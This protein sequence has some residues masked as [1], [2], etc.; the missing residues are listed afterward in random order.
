MATRF[1]PLVLP[2]QLH[3]FPQSYSQRIKLYDAERNFSAQKH[4]YWFNYFIDLEE[5]D[6]ANVKIRLFTQIFSG[7]V[8]KWFKSLLAISIEDFTS[9]ETYFITRWGYKKNPLQLLTQ[10]NNMKRDSEEIVQE[11]LTCFMK[12]YNSTS[13]EVQRPP[14]VP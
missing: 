8:R 12:V 6:Y 10:Y 5:V 2:T 14:K 13:V 9:F 3:D 4:V 7:E 1:S 11:F